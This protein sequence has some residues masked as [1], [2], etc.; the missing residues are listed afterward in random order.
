[1]TKV[2]I[3]HCADYNPERVDTAMKLLLD[4]LGIQ[5]LFSPGEKILLKPNLLSAH[6]PKDCATTHPQVFAS[7][8]RFLSDRD[9]ILSY[10]DSPAMDSPRKASR[11]CGMEEVAN[12]LNIRP[13]DFENSYVQEFSKGIVAK[14]FTLVNA[15]REN[16]GIVNICKFKSHAM[17]R[18][19]GAMKNQ[20]GLVPGL[21]KAKDHVN[22][23]DPRKFAGMI[24]DLNRCVNA[25][26]HVVDAI[27]G[28]EGNG[29]AN[30]KPRSI[31]LILA[32]TD[33][34][35]L[36]SVCVTLIGLDNKD[37]DT[38]VLGERHGVGVSDLDRI[39]LTVIHPAKDGDQFSLERGIAKQLLPPM[40]IR[41]FENALNGHSGMKLLGTF[42]GTA[43]KRVILNRPVVRQEK[44]TRC[45][46][47]VGIC[48]VDPKAIFYSKKKNR[49][50][51]RY[52]DCI[53]CFCCQETC[54]Y[55]AIEVKKAPLGFL[56]K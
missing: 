18:F 13:A 33:P 42:L 47:C 27:M 44:C 34:V 50:Q 17:T 6:P 5:A 36:D 30:G 12:R 32:S 26:L 9:C 28:M 56:L 15:I 46:V 19:T 43:A 10:G 41:D 8:A 29:P 53:R 54:P 22:F 4:E 24:T 20:F 45:K 51:Y 16:D 37:I 40:V 2:C 7:V 48:P 55:G 14:R 52:Q 23:A 25:R 49:I 31:G 11:V 39:E 35:A 38:I 3:V 21:L 1:M